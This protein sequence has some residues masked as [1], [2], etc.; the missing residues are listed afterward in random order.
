VK[1]IYIFVLSLLFFTGTIALAQ[2]QGKA[3][4]QG[5]VYNEKNNEPLPFATI[6]IYGTTIGSISDLDGNF[7]FT[8]VDPGFIRLQV[9]SVGFETLVTEEF[10]ATSARQSYIEIPMKEAN[11]SLSEVTVKASPFRKQEE[12]PVSLKTIQISEIEKNPGGNRDISKVLQSF[13]GV[14]GT[15]SFRND[16]I[17]RGG[18]PSENRFYLDGIEI[19]NLNHFSTQGASGGAVGIINVDFIRQ[20]QY[21][22]GAFP[23]SRGNT[24]SS[25]FEFN[26]FD[27]NKEKL[28][29]KGSVGA[30]DLALALNGPLSDNT[31]FFVSARRSYLQLLFAALQLPFLPTYNDFQFKVKTRIDLKNEISFIGIGA[32]DNSSLNLKAN[33]TPEQRYILEY[34]PENIQWNYAIGAVYKHYQERGFYTLVL[35]R[36]FLNN[37][38][39]KYEQNNKELGINFD[40]S[41]IESEN[42]LRF[43]HFSRTLN[44]Y[45]IVYGI[46]SEYAKYENNTRRKIFIADSS[47]SFD[48]NSLLNIIHYGSFFQVSRA[49]FQQRLTLS[50]GTRIDGSSYSTKMSNPFRHFSPR[51]SVSW[52]V[53]NK[54]FLNANTGRYYQRPAYT[55]FGYRDASGVLV[56]KEN[57]LTYIST[58]HFVAGIE[59]RASD[60]SIITIEGFYKK[61]GNYPFSLIDSI[62]LASKGGDYGTF[63]D[64]PVK[65]VSEGRSYGFEIFSKSSNI[66]GFNTTLSYT[67]VISQFKDMDKNLKPLSTY[68]STS[69]DN[70]HILFITS[71]RKFNRNWFAGFK[72]R[73]VGAAPYTEYDTEKSS[74]KMAWDAQGRAYLDYNNFNKKRL[75]PFHQLD[76]RIDKEYYF[77]KWSINLY[78][79]IQNLYNNKSATPDYLVREAT[80]YGQ[81]IEN[82][83]YVDENGIERYKLIRVP[84]DGQGT[85]LPTIGLIIEF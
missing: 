21:Y 48:Y 64:E 69:W 14:G 12:S 74:R 26:Q 83:P 22:S 72:W 51:L 40:Y 3:I 7:L 41:S 52:Q 59:Y 78:I 18:G 46:S 84:S 77:K 43:E 79:D 73:F 11:I 8:G 35:S 1:T 39:Y 4:I 75:K 50:A 44:D 60:K 19:P 58:N 62:S 36:N 25:V 66:F 33:E 70:R 16:L 10:Q 82:D 42:K 63:G 71:S 80:F 2:Q 6:V 17:I 15:V 30:T 29:F 55:T 9:S 31:T 61:Y 24:L 47:A 68:T 57:G 34:L 28:N 85:V 13:P 56:N 49:Y 54:L 20:V 81:T 76:V 53:G 27:G 37:K 23:A 5:R 65:S 38:S 32:I 67:F 45:K